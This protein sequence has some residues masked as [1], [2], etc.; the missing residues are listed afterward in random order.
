MVI[1]VVYEADNKFQAMVTLINRDFNNQTGI[2]YCATI[3]QVVKLSWKLKDAGILNEQ[4]H[5][6]L[7]EEQ[8]KEVL[9]RW[10]KGEIK[11]IVATAAFGMGINMRT[12]RF[13][14]HYQMPASLISY[15]QE[16]GRAGRDGKRSYVY[17]FFNMR[18]YYT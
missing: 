3:N 5:G 11:V 13:I 7:V 18:D 4:F 8:K 12:V 16:I 2:I 1:S 6:K 9:S 15:V 17:L 14:I 10:L